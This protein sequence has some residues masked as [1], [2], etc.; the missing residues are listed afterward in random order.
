MPSTQHYNE[1]G[2]ELQSLLKLEHPPIGISFTNEPPAGVKKMSGSVPSG[3]VFWIKAF[4]EQFYTTQSD[5]ANCSIGSFTHGFLP[6]SQVSLDSCPDIKLMVEADYLALRDFGGVPRMEN[7]QKFVAY[8]PLKSTS[9]EPDVILMICNAEQSMLVTE[10]AP[11]YKTMGKP[12]CA[13]IPYAYGGEDVAISFGCVTNRVRTGLKPNEL[14]VTI[15]VTQLDEF[16]A[17]LKRTVKSNS[18]VQQAVAAML[19]N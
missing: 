17:K 3:C 2:I 18:S 4:T 8:A 15:P 16:V 6:S 19:T 1:L 13:A 11:S 7:K 14:V 12:T 5:H 9:F 10:A